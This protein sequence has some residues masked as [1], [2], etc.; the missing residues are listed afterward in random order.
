[1]SKEQIEKALGSL[2]KILNRKKSKIEGTGF[3]VREDGYLMTCHHVIISLDELIVE[4]SGKSY[5]AEYCEGYSNPN[6][7]VAILKIDVDKAIPLKIIDPP[8]LKKLMSDIIVLGFPEA[9]THYKPLGTAFHP[10]EI[11][12]DTPTTTLRTFKSTE[13]N[14]EKWGILPDEDATFKP[15]KLN[16]E[17][18][19]GTSGG[20]VFIESLGG[21]IGMIQSKEGDQEKAAYAV[22]WDNQPFKGSAKLVVC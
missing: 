12:I 18:Y 7:D 1:M 9:T 15:F 8:D 21:A 22:R 3:L 4:Y 20:P 14:N 17:V 19:P 5:E 13:K 2:V 11:I 6:V 16:E 10:K